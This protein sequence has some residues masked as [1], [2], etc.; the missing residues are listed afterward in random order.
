MR[1]VAV[2]SLMGWVLCGCGQADQPAPGGAAWGGGAP[3]A[4]PSAVAAAPAAEKVAATVSADGKAMDVDLGAGVKMTLLSVP[5]GEFQM[6]AP[7]GEKERQDYETPVHKVKIT[8]PFFIGKFEV[9][10]AQYRR[11]RP[12]HRPGAWAGDDLPALFVSWHDAQAFCRFLSAKT[13]RAFRLPT[14]AEWEY[15]CRAGTTTRYYTGD[16]INGNKT[17]A[18]LGQAG[19]YGAISKGAPRPVGK[20]AP[21][22]FGLYDMHG[23][24]W[25]WCGDWFGA[26]YYKTSPAADPTGPAAGRAKVLRG[27]CFW[28]WEVYYFRSAAR[29]A[30]APAAREPVCGFRVVAGGKTIAPP[31]SS[32]PWPPPR[33][34]PSP[35]MPADAR[36]AEVARTFG[37]PAVLVPTVKA[38]KIDGRLDDAAWAKARGL[39]FRFLTGRAGEPEAAT[40]ARVV[41]DGKNLYF[42]FAC[43]EPDMGRLAI[44]GKNRDDDVW[45]GDTAEIFLDPTHA[46]S[47]EAYYH[48]AVNPAGVTMDT[49]GG[50]KAWNPKLKVATLRRDVGWS[51]EV[52]ISLAD[53]GV[54]PGQ[55]PKV[56]G[57]NLTRYRPEI[58]TGKPR[59][60]TL[61]PH[62]WPVDRPDLLRLAEDTGWAATRT[63]TS[64]WPEAFGHAVLAAG[65]VKTP[66]PKKL[67]RLIRR[68]DF[69]DGTP[70][71]F[72]RGSVEPGGYMGVGKALRLKPGSPAPLL[73]VPMTD[74]RDVQLLTILKTPGGSG[75]YW[76]TFGKM[77]GT[78]KACPRQVTTLIR[79]RART[80]PA[81]NYCDGA[82]RID[83]TSKGVVDPYYAGFIKHLSWFSEPTIGRIHFTGPD[84]WA[85]VYTRVGDLQTQHPHN[86]RIQADKDSIPGWFLHAS[87]Q[88]DVLV[89][90]AVLFAGNDA[91]PP[92]APANVKCTAAGDTVTVSWD[93][94]ADNTLTIWYQVTAGTGKDARVVAEAAALSATLPRASVKGQPI[95]VRAVDFF[96]NV[97]APSKPVTAD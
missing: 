64:H 67:F 44:A 4:G 53:L 49:R 7:A 39:S 11:F 52:A 8:Q 14:E 74:F 21:N 92:E 22:A 30:F 70:G 80:W 88:Y 79:R 1:R 40:R 47:L 82:G 91:E 95:T 97:S 32:Q 25:E 86:K 41:C 20:K 9:T 56:W 23:N 12:D 85:V 93:R 55:V 45:H 59:L 77:Y 72:S 50:D 17:S 75:I 16:A 94:S 96:E 81:F 13:G 10:N 28:Y 61:V 3:L 2:M 60:G 36:A 15:A 42:A 84:Q 57:M 78:N 65:T 43:A 46:E 51:V 26:D 83:A 89:S 71:K 6:G 24:A 90:D 73:A 19:W 35:D 68:E 87:G 58:A 31:K 63:D 33:A 69:A 38:P 5:A 27:G 34:I 54:K 18:P 37:G 66:A 29:Y 48:V 62:S 76:H